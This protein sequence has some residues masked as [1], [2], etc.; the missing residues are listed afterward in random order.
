MSRSIKWCRFILHVIYILSFFQ[1]IVEIYLDNIS[2]CWAA[3]IIE[4]IV[5][6]MRVHQSRWV[7]FSFKMPFKICFKDMVKCH[8]KIQSWPVDSDYKGP[9]MRKSFQIMTTPCSVQNVNTKYSFSRS[10]CHGSFWAR[11]EPMRDDDVTSSLNDW[12]HA[13]NDP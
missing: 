1:I 7:H 12:A 2:N 10:D 4:Y 9:V 13:Q 11:P 6:S 8:I 3:T 5:I